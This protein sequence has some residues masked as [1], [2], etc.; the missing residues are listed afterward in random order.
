MYFCTK[1]LCS[2]Y[3][4]IFILIL[5][6]YSWKMNIEMNWKQFRVKISQSN[7]VNSVE[8]KP[9]EYLLS[10]LNKINKYNITPRVAA[11]RIFSCKI[12]QFSI[13]CVMRD[14]ATRS[15]RTTIVS[16]TV[17]KSIVFIFH[18]LIDPFETNHMHIQD[19]GFRGPCLLVYRTNFVPERRAN[20][21]FNIFWSSYLCD[22]GYAAC[23]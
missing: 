19:F 3:D 4:F 2:A 14:L 20:T 15:R 10:F 1:N 7:W 12:H 5:E 9:K 18:S 16:K 23:V 6:L 22:F 17:R 8:H 11:K 21:L 13:V